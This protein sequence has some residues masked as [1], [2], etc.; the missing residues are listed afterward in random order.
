MRWK[1]QMHIGLLV[2][3]ITGLIY[4]ASVQAANS[5]SFD[6]VLVVYDSLGKGTEEEGNIEALKRLLAS[7]RVQVTVESINSYTSGSLSNY[8]KLIEVHNRSDLAEEGSEYLTDLQVYRGDMLYIGGMPRDR[9][10][11][12]LGL[13][14][15]A[16]EKV[17]D[18]SIGPFVEKSIRLKSVFDSKQ[19]G[20]QRYGALK[21]QESSYPY[22]I[23]KGPDAYVPFME[24]DTLSEIALSYVLKDWLRQEQESHYYLVFKEIYPF[25]DLRLLERMSDELYEAGI[26]FMVSVHPVFSNTDYPAMKR[27]INTLKYVQSRNGTVL[28]ESPFVATVRDE[29]R[30]LFHQ[31]EHFIDVLAEE[32]VVPLGM[33]TGMFWTYDNYFATEGMTF[34]DSVVLFP[35]TRS[36]YKSERN[37]SEAFT[38]SLYSVDR[39]ICS[40]TGPMTVR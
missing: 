10:V 6:S 11:Q 26:P 21:L 22:G 9:L 37:H 18:F 7:F 34:F 15:Q 28:V 1:H 19:P 40:V 2:L 32:G 35:D 30:D 12:S 5:S 31:M 25:S 36:I 17:A 14:V 27:Y 4:P 13:Q 29:G 20:V 16:L 39:R 38:S 24:K 23:R 3:L 8:S 33:G